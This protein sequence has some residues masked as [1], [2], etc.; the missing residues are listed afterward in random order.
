MGGSSSTFSCSCLSFSSGK[1]RGGDDFDDDWE[2]RGT[3]KIRPSDED[4]KRW[5]GEPDVD[6]K[7]SDFIAKFYEN[8][9]TDP[10]HITV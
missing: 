5:V 4:G 9:H 10:E 6:R 3:R 1:S 2:W 7:A 8:R